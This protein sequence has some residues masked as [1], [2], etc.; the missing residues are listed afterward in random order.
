MNS[1]LQQ[2]AEQLS[3]LIRAEVGGLRTEMRTEIGTLRDDVGGL[4]SDMATFKDEMRSDMATF[5]DEMRSDMAT[6]KDEVSGE[7]SG[8]RNELTERIHET[9]EQFAALLATEI[10]S[11]HTHLQDSEGRINGKMDAIQARM[12]RHAGMLRSGQV[13]ILRLNDWSET[14]DKLMADRDKRIDTLEDR[15]RKLED[16]NSKQ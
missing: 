6:F 4:R 11:L 15:L 8:L 9:K 13:A 7:V 1:E 5:K 3:S 2:V 12:D 16:R 14:L 10:G